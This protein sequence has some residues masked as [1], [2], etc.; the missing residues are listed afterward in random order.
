MNFLQ[1]WIILYNYWCL[2]KNIRHVK[3]DTEKEGISFKINNK[4]WRK[5]INFVDYHISQVSLHNI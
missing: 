3:A 2:V 5:K 4:N 1:A